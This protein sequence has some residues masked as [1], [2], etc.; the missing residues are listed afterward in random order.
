MATTLFERFRD[1]QLVLT[2][3]A[4]RAGEGTRLE[5]YASAGAEGRD[6]VEIQDPAEADLLAH[7]LRG[8]AIAERA[9]RR[10]IEIRRRAAGGAESAPPGTE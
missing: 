8:W 10:D 6:P 3:C 1:G 9:R 5:I 4:N 2:R 7:Q